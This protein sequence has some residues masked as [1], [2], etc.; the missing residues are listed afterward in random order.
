MEVTRHF[1]ATTFVVGIIIFITIGY[2]FGMF[3]KDSHSAEDQF[4]AW[5]GQHEEELFSFERDRDKIFDMLDSELS[6]IHQGLTFEFGPIIDG[7]RDF[8]ISAG[9]IH[10]TF[11]SV[12][13]L[14][15]RAPELSRWNVKQFRQRKQNFADMGID[16]RGHVFD[17]SM[18]TFKLHDERGRIG[19]AI[20][21]EGLTDE[22]Q[23]LYDEAGFIFLDSALGEYDVETKLGSLDFL[24]GADPK[25]SGAQPFSE[26][27]KAFDDVLTASGRGRAF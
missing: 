5:F 4:W 12:Q 26:L 8:V 17:P 21:M 14:G 16:L 11:P 13:R 25:S 2:M 7:R 9:G 24:S 19:L 1:T 27:P 10:E 15:D 3:K 23:D 6:K 20:F 18:I 22:N